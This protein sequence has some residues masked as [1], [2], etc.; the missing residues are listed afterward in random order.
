MVLTNLYVQ[1]VIGGDLVVEWRR[2]IPFSSTFGDT[3]TLDILNGADEIQ[4][5]NSGMLDDGFP[6]TV[7][8]NID[9]GTYRL[10]ATSGAGDMSIVEV[11]I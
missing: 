6:L 5:S 9:P 3:F 7:P 4:S 10:R 2:N 11:T 8:S 1:G